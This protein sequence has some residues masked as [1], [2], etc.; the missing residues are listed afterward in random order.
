MKRS[1]RLACKS[2]VRVK[3]DTLIRNSSPMPTRPST[4]GGYDAILVPGGFGERGVE[5]KIATAHYA[6]EHKVPYLGICLGMQVATIEFARNVL[7]G[8]RQLHRV[9]PRHHP[10]R[11]RLDYRV[12]R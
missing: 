1:A 6:R 7:A 3:I 11:H 12:E 4:W 5:G 8:R 9:R 10:P 2:H